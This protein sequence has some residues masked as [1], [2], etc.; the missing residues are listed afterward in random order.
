MSL[1][2]PQKPI[3]PTLPVPKVFEDNIPIAQFDLSKRY[4]IYCS[5]HSEDRLYEDVKIVGMRTLERRTEFSS[6]AI[7]G[8]VEIES[9]NGTRAFI[10]QFHV[11][12]L[13]EHGA[14]LIDKVVRRHMTSLE[15]DAK[16]S[17]SHD[18]NA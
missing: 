13:C 16:A 12:I 7:G 8:Y 10:P 5:S 11:S 3:I 4:D 1:F 17:D 14:P 2:K 18:R 6:G 9:A 15:P